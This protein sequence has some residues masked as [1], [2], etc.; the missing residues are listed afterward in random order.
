MSPPDSTNKSGWS[1]P[2][3]RRRDPSA[4][5]RAATIRL[6]ELGLDPH[7]RRPILPFGFDT[8]VESIKQKF[9]DPSVLPQLASQESWGVAKELGEESSAILEGVQS[10][11]N[12]PR[13]FRHWVTRTFGDNNPSPDE[14]VESVSQGDRRAGRT[15]ESRNQ[16]SSEAQRGCVTLLPELPAGMDPN[17]PDNTTGAEH[18]LLEKQGWQMYQNSGPETRCQKLTPSARPRHG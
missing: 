15:S 14:L 1:D 2:P 7:D 3:S 4:P 9:P 18:E 12:S 17:N 11:P 8:T 6:F 13:T 5:H 16:R 10:A